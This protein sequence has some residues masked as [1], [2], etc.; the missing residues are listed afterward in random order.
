MRS[1]CLSPPAT[2]RLMCCRRTCPYL[3]AT[4]DSKKLMPLIL[5]SDRP[6]CSLPSIQTL[7]PLSCWRQAM[8]TWCWSIET[9]APVYITLRWSTT[10]KYSKQS[11]SP[12]RALSRKSL[13]HQI[14]QSKKYKKIGL[15]PKWM[16]AT[17]IWSSRWCCSMVFFQT[18]KPKSQS[19]ANSSSVRIRA[20]SIEG[21]T[22][23]ERHS[24]LRLPSTISKL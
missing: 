16:N 22:R 24:L 2:T 5:I 19:H 8:Q 17:T 11:S 1:V 13:M 7:M 15:A 6:L 3:P 4:S 14:P 9:A 23:A 10:Q 12:V 18:W 20:S 21:I